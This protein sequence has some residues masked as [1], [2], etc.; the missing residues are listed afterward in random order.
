MGPDDGLNQLLP[1]APSAKQEHQAEAEDKVPRQE[2]Q[3]IG[4][5]GRAVGADGLGSLCPEEISQPAVIGNGRL[6]EIAPGDVGNR[7]V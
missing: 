6:G 4:R 1:V 2:Q 5:Q 3:P 7:P